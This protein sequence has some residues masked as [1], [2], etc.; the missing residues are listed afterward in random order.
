MS[1][2]QTVRVKLTW[3]PRPF[4]ERENFLCSIS[5]IT[6]TWAATVFEQVTVERNTD[7]CRHAVCSTICELQL[8]KSKMNVKDLSE[9]T[10]VNYGLL[11][12]KIK[13]DLHR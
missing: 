2:R 8:F 9:L 13:A 6:G 3:S 7:H 11:Y 1:M 12:L 10:P 5:I 4:S